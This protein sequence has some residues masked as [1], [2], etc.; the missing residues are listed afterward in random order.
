MNP[1]HLKFGSFEVF[2]YIFCEKMG[3]TITVTDLVKS[4]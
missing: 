3:F 4:T 1:L 2:F